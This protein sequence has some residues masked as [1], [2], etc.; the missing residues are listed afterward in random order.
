MLHAI[1]N[2]PD[3]NAPQVKPALALSEQLPIIQ[4][5]SLGGNVVPF[6]QYGPSI[7]T[8]YSSST[9]EPTARL[10]RRVVLVSMMLETGERVPLWG[11]SV[12]GKGGPSIYGTGS[13]RASDSANGT[14]KGVGPG[15]T[16]AAGRI[17]VGNLGCG[18]AIPCWGCCWLTDYCTWK[19][20][21]SNSLSFFKL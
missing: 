1:D 7:V 10:L 3:Y 17:G 8:S 16:G 6:T 15:L 9:T 20:A 13:A 21:M 14:V 2:I 4:G 19:D 12:I 5:S 11:I 18:I